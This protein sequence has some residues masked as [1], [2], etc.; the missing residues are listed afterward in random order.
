MLSQVKSLVTSIHSFYDGGTGQS[1]A[2]N[3]RGLIAA[4]PTDRKPCTFPLSLSMSVS[5]RRGNAAACEECEWGRVLAGHEPVVHDRWCEFI[6]AST[7][8]VHIE[9]VRAWGTPDFQRGVAAPLIFPFLDD[10]WRECPHFSPLLTST[11]QTSSSASS[12][13]HNLFTLRSD[14]LACPIAP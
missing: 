5:R 3:T 4:V 11:N 14:L 1:N 10:L 8:L 7:R 9:N 13:T 12:T 6:C 2:S